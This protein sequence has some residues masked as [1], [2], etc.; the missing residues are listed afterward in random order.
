MPL[1]TARAV[2]SVV[3][4]LELLLLVVL[5]AG[6]PLPAPMPVAAEAAAATVLTLELLVARRLFRAGRRGGAGRRAALS[7]TVA[8]LVPPLVRRRPAGRRPR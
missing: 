8:H 2:L 4:P 3:P 1:R 7:A 5:A 6:V